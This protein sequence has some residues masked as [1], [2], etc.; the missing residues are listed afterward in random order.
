MTLNKNGIPAVARNAFRDMPSLEVVR[1]DDNLIEVVEDR[2]LVDL[3]SLKE[4]HLQH[5]L[6]EEVNERAFVNIHSLRLVRDNL[7]YSNSWLHA[8]HFLF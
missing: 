5:N 8:C 1:L 7:A 3:Y 2:A 4:L 6:I